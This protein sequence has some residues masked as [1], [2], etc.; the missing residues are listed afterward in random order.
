MALIIMLLPVAV[1]L[2]SEI[3]GIETPDKKVMASL[4]ILVMVPNSE[5]WLSLALSHFY[6]GLAVALILVSKARS[7]WVQWFRYVVLLT[8]GLNTP[9]PGFLVPFFWI[10]WLLNRD[11][12]RLIETVAISLSTG[13]QAW[14]VLSLT[15]QGMRE[16]DFTFD[17]LPYALWVKQILLPLRGW[18]YANLKVPEIRQ[19]F[20]EGSGVL[21]WLIPFLYLLVVACLAKTRSLAAAFLFSSSLMML[22]LSCVFAIG[23]GKSGSHLVHIDAVIAGRYYYVPTLL[24]YLSLLSISG[25]KKDRIDTTVSFM[26]KGIVIWIILIGLANYFPKEGRVGFSFARGPSWRE[27]VT[28][29]R[30]NPD[31]RIRVWP[32]SWNLQLPPKK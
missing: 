28:E 14:I 15:K 13:I 24:L 1:I 26:T 12:T 27:E 17:Y 7:R 6:Q 10:A 16:P 25:N 5:T 23:L 18:E 20:Q 22:I 32:E 4:L 9:F 11:R 19:A 8:A 29:W 3:K 21:P 2:F 30:Q 31:H